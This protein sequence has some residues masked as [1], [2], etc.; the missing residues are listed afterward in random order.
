MIHS[1][2]IFC[3]SPVSPSVRYLRIVFFQ[4]IKEWGG[5]GFYSELCFFAFGSYIY[6]ETPSMYVVSLLHLS[7]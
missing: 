3:V 7:R 2:R 5:R 6:R 1:I 4:K